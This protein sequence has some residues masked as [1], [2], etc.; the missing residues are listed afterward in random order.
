MKVDPYYSADVIRG[1]L[2]IDSVSVLMKKACCKFA[3]KGYYDLGPTSLN[4]M[5]EV[6]ICDREV[7]SNDQLKAV[8]P[9]CRT[10][11]GARNFAIRAVLYWNVLP[12]IC[13]MATSPV[14]FKSLLKELPDI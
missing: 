13:R 4:S 7:R 3:Y 14:A 1:E 9:R 5:F 6:Y 10:Q 12:V 8:V 2:S 11:F